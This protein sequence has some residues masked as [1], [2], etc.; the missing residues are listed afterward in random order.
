MRP[1]TI[2]SLAVAATVL[3][4]AIAQSVTDPWAPHRSLKVL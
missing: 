4:P 2:L 1:I 3:Q